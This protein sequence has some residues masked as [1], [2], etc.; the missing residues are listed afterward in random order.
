MTADEY[1]DGDNALPKYY[2][3][4]Y[5]MKQEQV[6]HEAWFY[7]MYVYDALVSAM[8]HLS[9]KKSDHKSYA[10]KPYSFK[11]EDIKKDNEA[12]KIEAEARAE[13][14]M[15]TWVSATQKMFKDK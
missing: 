13:V 4:A 7:G 10:E 11:P 1:W 14:W 8:S 6:N 3:E 15:K 12:K 2:R 9:S 5:R